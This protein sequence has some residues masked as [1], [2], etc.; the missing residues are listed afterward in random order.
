MSPKVTLHNR[1]VLVFVL[2]FE[3]MKCLTG[4]LSYVVDL[5]M[6]LKAYFFP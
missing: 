4:L 6:R 1:I 2:L 5:F 3:M